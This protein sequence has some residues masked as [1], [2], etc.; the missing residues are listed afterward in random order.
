M[1]APATFTKCF[2]SNTAGNCFIAEGCIST[3]DPA[4][5]Y[6]A[7]FKP[8]SRPRTMHLNSPGVKQS[9]K[10]VFNAVKLCEQIISR[11]VRGTG[12]TDFSVNYTRIATID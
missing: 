6:S 1:Q 9:I 11:T 10:A 2:L 3:D 7:W 8:S 4:S 5:N 12:R